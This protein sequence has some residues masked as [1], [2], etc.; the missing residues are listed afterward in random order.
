MMI[1]LEDLSALAARLLQENPANRLYKTDRSMFLAPLVGAQRGDHPVFRKLQ[2]LMPGHLLPVE[3]FAAAFPDREVKAVSVISFSFP[4]HPDTVKEN[5][6]EKVR[7][8]AS[9]LRTRAESDVLF[10]DVAAKL[11]DHLRQ[12]GIRAMHTQTSA[13]YKVPWHRGAP[14]AANWSE[15]HVAYA[16]GLGTFGLHHGLIT[17]HGAAHRLMSLLVDAPCD[18]SAMAPENPFAA[19]L[20]LTQGKC[21]VCIKRCPAGAIT[22]AGLD[23]E[24]CRKYSYAD[25]IEYSQELVGKATGGCA[26]CMCGV[27][28]STCD[29]VQE[30]SSRRK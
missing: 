1:K 11:V 10:R 18:A 8:S 24:A 16:C 22:A 28:C 30:Q 26:L 5:S 19:C 7:P 20:Y 27:P 17:A 21:G 29:P 25:M 12:Q 6:R 9:W 23:L 14:L 3:M 15:R 4:I 13:L 2:E